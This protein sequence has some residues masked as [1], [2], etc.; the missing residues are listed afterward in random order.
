MNSAVLF[1]PPYSQKAEWKKTD[2][3]PF[4]V[5]RAMESYCLCGVEWEDKGAGSVKCAA[6]D[7]CEGEDCIFW[8][9][10]YTDLGKK[11]GIT[12]T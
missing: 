12:G 9:L 2:D 5:R 10:T 3:L 7:A 8:K 1:V 4:D 11:M 6:N